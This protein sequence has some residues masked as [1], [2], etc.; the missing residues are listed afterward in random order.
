[1]TSARMW[2]AELYVKALRTG[3]A[4]ALARLA[5]HVAAD[6]VLSTGMAEFCGRDA[7]LA[8]VTG[9]WPQ[10]IVY[11]QGAWGY[12]VEADETVT[13]SGSFPKVGAAPEV[14][15]LTFRFDGSDKIT[16]I[17]QIS[18]TRAPLD[19]TN[20]IPDVARGLINGALANGTPLLMACTDSGGKPLLSVRG[21]VQTY[22]D[23]QL[24]AWLRHG[25]GGTAEALSANPRCALAYWD[26]NVRAML[27]IEGLGKVSADERVRNRVYD[28]SPEV[29]QLHDLDRKGAA[30]IVDITR[31]SG[32]TSAGLLSMVRPAALELWTLGSR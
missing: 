22:S 5:D 1:M 19:V 26:S 7:L 15:T 31:M 12:P 32:F 29:E 17:E 27:N 18:K 6:A 11:S 4:S 9:Q 25:D 13:V 21:S 10:T 23:Y 2:A 24:A 8:R 16:R 30:L 28:L 14:I 20:T 3:E